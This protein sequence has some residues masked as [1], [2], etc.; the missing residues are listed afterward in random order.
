MAEP[1]VLPPQDGYGY[2]LV[3][4]LF[5]TTQT[6][7]DK[8]AGWPADLRAREEAAAARWR[9]CAPAGAGATD[10][11]QRP[12]PAGLAA[13]KIIVIDPGHGGIDSGTVGVTGHGGEGRGAGRGHA[14]GQ[15]AAGPRLHGLS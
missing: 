12:V 9:P 7:F 2:R 5:P 4:D 11:A 13:R 8:T 6:A 10:G 14:P 15:G 1:M 3:L